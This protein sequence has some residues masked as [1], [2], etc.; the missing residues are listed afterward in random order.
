VKRLAA[1]RPYARDLHVYGGGALVAGGV[2][3]WSIPASL[4]VFGAVLIFRGV[5][6]LP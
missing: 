6:R 5:W 2:A 4:I 1:L 3:A